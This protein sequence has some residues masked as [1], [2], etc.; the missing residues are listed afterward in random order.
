[1]GKHKILYVDDEVI[2][3]ELFKFN[4]R[5]RYD[6]LI[7]ENGEIGLDRISNNPDILVIISD[8]KMPKMNGCQFIKKVKE[9]YSHLKCFILTGF[10]V[11]PEIQ[12]CINNG[13]IIDCF[14]KP[15]DSSKI[16]FEISNAIGI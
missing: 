15:M 7:A 2:N 8:M 12:E 1:M 14:S 13:L 4:L 6:V 3:L 9:K 10:E 5:D 16:D 11:T